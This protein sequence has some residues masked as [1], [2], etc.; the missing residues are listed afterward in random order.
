METI[1]ATN[2]VYILLQLGNVVINHV[3]MM[4]WGG[5]WECVVV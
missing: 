3:E 4:N 5:G 1:T 2:V